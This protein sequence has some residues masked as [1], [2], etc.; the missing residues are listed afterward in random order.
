MVQST[1]ITVT[2]PTMMHDFAATRNHAIFMD[3]PAIFDMELA[4]KGGMP[5]RWSDDYPA[6]FGICPARAATP[7]S[8]GSTSSR[9][10][11]STP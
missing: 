5:I 8:A 9:A 1:E 3:L 10:T 4:M 7:T 6:R 2:G 11:A